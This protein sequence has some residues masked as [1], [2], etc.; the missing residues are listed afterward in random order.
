MRLNRIVL[1]GANEYTDAEALISLCGKLSFVE[2][3]LFRLGQI[4]VDSY[5]CPLFLAE[6]SSGTA[7]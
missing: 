5:A 3:G 6:N 2:I 1:S 7:S 4:L